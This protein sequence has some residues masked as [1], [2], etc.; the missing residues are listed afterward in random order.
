MSGG[1]GRPNR[2]AHEARP[3][4][5]ISGTLAD[6][7]A[8]VGGTGRGQSRSVRARDMDSSWTLGQWTYRHEEIVG[9]VV[10]RGEQ[11]VHHS[12]DELYRARDVYEAAMLGL[13]FVPSLARAQIGVDIEE[14]MPT[15]VPGVLLVLVILG[16][17]T[18]LG[19]PIGAAIGSLAGSLG[20]LPG[21]ALSGDIGL[22]AGSGVFEAMGISFLLPGLSAELPANIRTRGKRH[23]ECLELWTRPAHPR[24]ERRGERRLPLRQR[25]HRVSRV[26]G[27]GFTRLSSTERMAGR[28]G[29]N[30]L[31]DS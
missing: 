17:T 4:V 18:L 13:S 30:R 21:A 14:L 20:S 8:P 16:D 11:F 31:P 6:P 25:R 3:A 24:V 9:S 26:G 22:D 12:E 19:A 15:F 27:A 7:N 29:E 23:P 1:V 5:S 2:H 10:H 28:S